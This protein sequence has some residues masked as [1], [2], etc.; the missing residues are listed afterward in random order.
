MERERFVLGR[1]ATVA[2]IDR[3]ARIEC[4][5]GLVWITGRDSAE[6]MILRAGEARDLRGLRGICVQALKD[7]EIGIVRD[8][9]TPL[10]ARYRNHR[11]HR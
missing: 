8:R 7:A 11:N 9:R 1:N 3:I 5:S 10:R 6:D 4:A 2:G